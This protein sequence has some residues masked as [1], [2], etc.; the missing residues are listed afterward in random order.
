MLNWL[1]ISRTPPPGRRALNEQLKR[2]QREKERRLNEDE[3][4][5]QQEQRAKAQERRAKAQE[6]RAQEES[7]KQRAK[8]QEKRAQEK[9]ATQCTKAPQVGGRGSRVFY[10]GY[11][12][13]MKRLWGK[14]RGICLSAL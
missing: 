14:V 10:W 6:R 5:R 13:K 8:A 4:G 11:W 7:A 1:Q 12:V 3:N 9:S 2:Q